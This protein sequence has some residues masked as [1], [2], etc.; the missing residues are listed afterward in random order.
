MAR[1]FLSPPHIGPDE[2]ALVTEAFATNWVAPVG[3]HVD[4][5]EA[6]FAAYVGAGHAVALSSG[7][8]ALHLAL[9][10]LGIGPG[11]EVAVSDL[12]FCASVN[13]IL[14]EGATPVFVD[15]E[16]RSWNLDPSLVEDLFRDRAASGRQIKAL[17]A[18][19]LYGQTADL[20]A[21]TAL[22]EQYGVTLI[23]DAAEALGASYRGRSPGVDGRAGIFSFNG[24]KIITTSGGGMLVTDRAETAAHVKKMATQARENAP[25]YEHA[26]IG[27]NYRMSNLLA[28]VGRGQLRVLDDRVA[29]RRAVFAAYQ[30]AL[31]GL[32]G[33]AFMPEAEWGRASRWLTCLTID[34]RA[35]GATREDV[36]LAM[37]AAD[38]EARPVWKPMHLQPVYAGVEVVGGAVGADL[39]EHGLCLPSGSAMT[40]ADI[41]RVC[42]VVAA[43]ADEGHVPAARHA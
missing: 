41:A 29:A 35:F 13:P 26:E 34:P 20:D 12:T 32:P 40:E 19:H 8:A 39:F 14:Y 38:I 1:L 11:D 10:D 23:E 9:R 4:A 24:N 21:L 3:P 2:L 17:V 7:T 15:S 27:F 42:A 31:G 43:C 37:E 18:V 16:R 36:R 5:F 33:I 30:T 6:E 22:C 25:H 28:G